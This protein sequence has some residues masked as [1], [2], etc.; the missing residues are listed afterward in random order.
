MTPCAEGAIELV[1]GKARVIREELC[2][3]AGFC[4][5]V[6]PTGAMS[7]EVREAPAFD[8]E[9]AETETALRQG[10]YMEQTCHVCGSGEQE[11]VLLP[12]RKAGA[13]VWVCTQCLPQLIHG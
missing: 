13:S 9:A 12:C 5:G 6:C 1:D 4:I 3:G 10:D 7:M 8:E 11:R 2:D